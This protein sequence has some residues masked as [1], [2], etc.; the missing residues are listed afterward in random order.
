MGEDVVL[1]VTVVRGKMERDSVSSFGFEMSVLISSGPGR[2]FTTGLRRSPDSGS[3]LH[4]LS[5]PG[6]CRRVSVDVERVGNGRS[7][8]WNLRIPSH[9][10]S[11]GAP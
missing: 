4:M 6:R 1:Q 11:L 5:F 3:V 2:S 7:R 9:H 8:G 10:T